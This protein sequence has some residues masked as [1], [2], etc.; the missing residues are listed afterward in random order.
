[1]LIVTW[2]YNALNR[3]VR[4]V[5]VNRSAYAISFGG[6]AIAVG[7]TI[8]LFDE[9]HKIWGGIIAL[10]GIG[11]CYWSYTQIGAEEWKELKRQR[12]ARNLGKDILSEIEDVNKNISNLVEEIRKDRTQ[13]ENEKLNKD[14]QK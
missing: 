3:W 9:P 5:K 13:K 10:L 14:K 6:V 7:I 4:R 8:M 1:M 2:L 12:D 11:M